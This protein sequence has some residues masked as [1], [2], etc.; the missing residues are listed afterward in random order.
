LHES[1]DVIEFQ[2]ATDA[3]SIL[4]HTVVIYK[5]EAMRSGEEVI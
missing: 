3:C 2:A 4:G 5:T 1:V